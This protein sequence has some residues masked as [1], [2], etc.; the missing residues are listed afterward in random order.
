MDFF[1]TGIYVYRNFSSEKL[2]YRWIGMRGPREDFIKVTSNGLE[3]NAFDTNIKAVAPISALFQRQM[4]KTFSATTTLDFTPG[5]EKDLAGMVCYQSEQFNYVFGITK[6][7]ND[8]YLLL[9]RTERG[10]SKLL[11]A[12]KLM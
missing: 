11:Q 12:Q 4:H 7:G 9:E 1:P 5:S 2:D 10:K 6:K 3:I 8:F